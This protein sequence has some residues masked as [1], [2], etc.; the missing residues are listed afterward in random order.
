MNDPYVA[1]AD[2]SAPLFDG[3]NWKEWVSVPG[4]RSSNVAKCL[5]EAHWRSARLVA[6]LVKAR[7]CKSRVSEGKPAAHAP[8][9]H[10]LTRPTAELGLGL[11]LHTLEIETLALQ[12]DKPLCRLGTVKCK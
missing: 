8:A 12:T 6:R 3:H 11:C 10:L 4:S 1:M 5:S 2:F 7:H 9:D